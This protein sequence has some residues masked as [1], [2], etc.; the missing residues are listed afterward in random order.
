M[1]D[2]LDQNQTQPMPVEPLQPNLV[3]H[4]QSTGTV[5]EILSDNCFAQHKFMSDLGHMVPNRLKI[6]IVNGDYANLG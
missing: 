3:D 2:T 6:K 4:D 1:A 5:P